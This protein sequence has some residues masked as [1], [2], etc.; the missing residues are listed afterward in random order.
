MSEGTRRQHRELLDQIGDVVHDLPAFLTAPLYRKW[1]LRWGA[2]PDEITEALP[3][4]DF[5][6][7]AQFQATRAITIDAPPDRVWPWLV[8]V[9][10]LR[11]GFY[12]DDLLDNL[13]RPSSRVVLPELQHLEVGNLVPMSPV[14][15]ESTSF[16]VASYAVP[17]E[18]LWTT[19]DSTWS[20]RLTEEAPG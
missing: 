16:R 17:H 1:H 20:W 10:C 6:P 3:G 12:S 4:D 8:Q 7:R 9:G 18:L 14:P 2:S 5:L 19:P 15:T 13:G 11:A